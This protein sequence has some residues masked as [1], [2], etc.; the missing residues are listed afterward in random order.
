[1]PIFLFASIRRGVTPE[2]NAI[3]TVLLE[4]DDHDDD[5]G[6]A[7]VPARAAPGGGDDAGR[8]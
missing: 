1:M 4:R 2:V 7:R 6:R 8:R 5:H 3:A